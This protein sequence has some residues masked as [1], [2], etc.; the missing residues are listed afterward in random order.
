MT[1]IQ[2]KLRASKISKRTINLREQLWP[3]LDETTLWNRKTAK[4][5]TTLPRTMPNL[6][7][8][9]DDLAGKGTPVS[10]VYLSLWCRVFDEA[11]VEI[12][13]YKDLAFEAGFNGQRA[14][15]MWKQRMSLLVE[16]GFILAE[17]GS[18][19]KYDYILLLN[20][21]PIIKKRYEAN[22]IQKFKY[23]T[24]FNRAQEIGAIDLE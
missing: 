2:T 8:I 13:S 3:N 23:I 7:E 12:K 14:V 6:L 16:L 24:L 20:P 17:E 22:D 21:Y 10:K 15:T 19:G 18:G 11:L 4:G 9:M 1:N 5:F